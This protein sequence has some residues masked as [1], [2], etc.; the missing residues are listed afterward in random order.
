MTILITGCAGFIGYHLT[1][2]LA[3]NKKNKILGVDSINKYYDVKLKK[4]R[5]KILK[6]KTNFKFHQISVVNKKD[7]QKIFKK[8]KIKYVVHL[9][10]QAGVRYSIN[11]PYTYFDNNILGFFNIIDLCRQF[12]I[13]HLV[14]A[15]T[16]SVYG[17]TKKFPN[18]EDDKNDYPQ[19]FYAASKKTN[20][21]IAHSYSAIYS[22]PTTGLRFFTV[23]GSFGRP[24]MALYKFVESILKNKIINIHNYGKHTRDFT[25][26]E[27]VVN[28]IIKIINKPSR[29]K[30]P[31]D[32]FNIGS[33]KPVK[34]LEYIKNIEFLLNIKSKKKLLPLQ[35]GDVIKT[36]SDIS[37]L[38][39]KTK[40]K[41]QYDIKR[42]L[43]EFIDW[44]KKYHKIK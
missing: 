2:R 15:S 6:K 34:L 24:D 20:E 11:N 23:Y 1:S 14:Y 33:S 12:K 27:D 10:A 32:I 18:K 37:K 22:L 44:Y 39:K 19:S 40:F 36:H 21:V 43:I 13:K 31:Y 4:D 8:N 35:N 3:L 38:M 25:H 28:G 16:S 5:L 30:I 41:I 7:L 26:V 9:A 29:N 42:G 17:D